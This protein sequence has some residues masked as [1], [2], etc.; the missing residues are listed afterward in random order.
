[1]I[2]TIVRFVVSA[3]VILL[4]SRLLPG[5][6][7]SGFT[8]ALVAAVSITVIGFAV[9]KLLGRKVS[10]RSRG[11]VGFLTASAVIYLVQFV[12]PGFLSVTLV[13]AMLAAF[14]VGIIDSFIPTEIR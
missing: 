8:G 13:G 7:V 14:V 6:S 4:V 11:W 1:V 10:P 9:E 3:L 12:I 2:G 5:F